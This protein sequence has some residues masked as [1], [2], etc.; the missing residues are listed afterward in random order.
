MHADHHLGTVRVLK[1]RTKYTNDQILVVAP[2]EMHGYLITTQM[3]FGNLQFNFMTCGD[4]FTIEG[5]CAVQPVPVIHR[6]LAYGFVLQHDSGWKIVYSGDTRPCDALV[7]AGLG[8]TLLIHEATF[9]D[10]MQQDAIQKTH[11]TFSEAITVGRAMGAWCT[12]LTHFSQ[13]YPQVAE[14]MLDRAIL[15]YDHMRFHLKDALELLACQ[16]RLARAMATADETEDED[17]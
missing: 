6:V 1:E 2:Y 11:S 8:A 17:S 15:A 9:E 12:L 4:A 16:K 14:N 7:E 5:I 10:S 13:R 3:L